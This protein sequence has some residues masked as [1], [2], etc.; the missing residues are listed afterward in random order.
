MSLLKEMFQEL[1]DAEINYKGCR[2]NMFGIPRF[3]THK[4]SI[5]STLSRMKKKGFVSYNSD[6]WALTSQGKKYYKEKTFF[7]PHFDSPFK[8]TPPKN[9]IVMFDIPETKKSYRDWLRKELKTFGYILIQQSVWVGPS[10]LPK[11]FLS[12]IE[13]TKLKQYIQTFKLSK[14]YQ[15][16]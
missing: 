10:P 6:G 15:R 7:L 4:R 2:V 5:S 11:E 13:E 9:L 8:N 16:K 12:F 1:W 14:G 3:L